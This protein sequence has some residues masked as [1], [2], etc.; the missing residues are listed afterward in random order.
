MKHRVYCVPYLFLHM[1]FDFA[2]F[3]LKYVYPRHFETNTWSRC[4]THHILFYMFALYF[5]KKVS[6]DFYG[7]Q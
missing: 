3:W 7:I 4:T 2:D 6:S 5:V 1:S